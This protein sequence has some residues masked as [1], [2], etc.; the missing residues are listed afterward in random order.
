M[1]LLQDFRL[2]WGELG[3]FELYEFRKKRTDGS[4]KEAV[5]LLPLEQRLARAISKLGEKAYDM[6]SNNCE[7]FIYWVSTGSSNSKQID[8]LMSV[9]IK[10][11]M[12][13]VVSVVVL[14]GMGVDI[15]EDCKYLQ[16]AL[17]SCP[18]E[19]MPNSTEPRRQILTK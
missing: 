15:F 18:D 19:A 3:H 13:G 11:A 17:Q 7:H 12:F 8:K 1:D 16:P 4:G 6:W 2:P 9:G 14:H 10:V 5:T